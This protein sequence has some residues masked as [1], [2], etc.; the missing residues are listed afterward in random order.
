MATGTGWRV[1]TTAKNDLA[2]LKNVTSRSAAQADT[3]PGV[4]HLRRTDGYGEQ[5]RQEF[6][7]RA[8]PASMGALS[9]RELG[10]EAYSQDDPGAQDCTLLPAIGGAAQRRRRGVPDLHDVLPRRPQFLTGICTAMVLP[11]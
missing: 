1:A 6:D 11:F 4:T 10:P 9:G 2:S 7:R 5:Q 8:V 3:V